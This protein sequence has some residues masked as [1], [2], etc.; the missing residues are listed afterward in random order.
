MMQDGLKARGYR[1]E[2]LELHGPPPASFATL[3]LD[4]ARSLLRRWMPIGTQM[5][6]AMERSAARYAIVADGKWLEPDDVKACQAIAHARGGR[7][8][9]YLCD[10]PFAPAYAATRWKNSLRHYDVVFATKRNIMADVRGAQVADLRFTWFAFDPTLHRTLGEIGALDARWRSDIAFAGGSDRDR[11]PIF[12]AL[13]KSMPECELSLYSSTWSRSRVLRACARPG[14][15]GLDYCRAML[16]ARICPCLVRRINRDGHVMRTFELLAMGCFML[17]E[18]TEEHQELMED[19]TH[20]IMW[21][22][23]EEL[24]DKCRWHLDRPKE[25]ERIAAAGCSLIRSGHHTYADRALE[26][27]DALGAAR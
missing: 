4:G 20:C 6:A 12:E 13:R 17:A 25:C 16:G 3:A 15:Y 22:S 27:L 11:V 23:V 1:T 19:G 5:R 7:I 24:V 18:R 21:G 9:T 2:F 14:A 10:D 26:V 8:A